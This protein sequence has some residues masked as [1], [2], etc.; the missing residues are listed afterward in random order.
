[1][2]LRA[3]GLDL[4]DDEVDS[5]VLLRRG[6]ADNDQEPMQASWLDQVLLSL[7]NEDLDCFFVP[8]K[9]DESHVPMAFTKSA[10]STKSETYHGVHCVSERVK[11]QNG[12]LQDRR[13]FASSE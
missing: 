5:V 4:A 2:Q 9:E 7:D 12:R 1:M 11:T 8:L 10:E 6:R 13:D 3:A